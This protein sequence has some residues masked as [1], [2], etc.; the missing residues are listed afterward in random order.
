MTV[1][2]T[3]EHENG[4]MTGAEGQPGAWAPYLPTAREYRPS[5]QTILFDYAGLGSVSLGDLSMWIW[6][7]PSLNQTWSISWLIR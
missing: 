4:R 5:A 7:P 1:P 2:V 3:I 6:V